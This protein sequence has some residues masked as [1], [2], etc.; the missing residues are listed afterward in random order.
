MAASP[1]THFEQ[2]LSFA[3]DEESEAEITKILKRYPPERKASAVIR[4]SARKP[5]L[6]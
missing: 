2:P 6:M 3:F 4:P 1:G 5:I